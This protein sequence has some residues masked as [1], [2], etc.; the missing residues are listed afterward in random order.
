MVLGIRIAVIALLCASLA[1]AGGEQLDEA[2]L[3]GGA[4]SVV[5]G[6]GRCFASY[7]GELF[8]TGLP[9]PCQ[10]LRRGDSDP[11]VHAYGEAGSVTL[12]SGPPAR[13]EDYSFSD[14]VAASDSCSHLARAIHFRDGQ[15]QLGE[16]LVEPLGFCANI[17]PDEKFYYGLAHPD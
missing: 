4:L 13:D 14:I 15:V 3:A 9:M 7:G 1:Q 17:A 6:G 12:L 5:D 8:D 2:T 11:I 10:F 16:M